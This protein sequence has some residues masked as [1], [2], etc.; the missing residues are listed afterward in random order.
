MVLQKSRKDRPLSSVKQL[1][2][3]TTEKV[4]KPKTRG[5][6]PSEA[7][8]KKNIEGCP[9]SEFGSKGSPVQSPSKRRKIMKDSIKT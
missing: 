3:T 6:K 9:L 7:Q 4:K 2:V 8:V 1:G 5:R